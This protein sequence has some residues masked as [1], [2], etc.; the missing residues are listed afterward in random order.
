ML[1]DQY[2]SRM[3]AYRPV[4][5]D[6]WERVSRDDWE[7][8]TC[9]TFRAIYRGSLTRTWL[10]VIGAFILGLPILCL[11]L[12]S[13]QS[14]PPPLILGP[15]FAPWLTAL[16]LRGHLIEA[17]M[18]RRYL[19]KGWPTRKLGDLLPCNKDGNQ[20][21]RQEH[22]FCCTD[23][24]IGRPV[25][26]KANSGPGPRFSVFRRTTDPPG[27]HLPFSILPRR[28]DQL[29]SYGSVEDD[30]DAVPLSGILRATAGFPGI[31]PRLFQ[32]KRLRKVP[33]KQPTEDDPVERAELQ[34]GSAETSNIILPSQ[35]F[36]SDGGIWN[37]LATEPFEDQFM[38]DKRGPWDMLVSDA[39][40][41]PTRSCR[42][43]LSIPGLA[44]L[45]ALIREEIILA[46]NTVGPRLQMYMH[47]VFTELRQPAA[48]RFQIERMYPIVS[49]AETPEQLV[50]RFRK[51][52]EAPEEFKY[53]ESGLGIPERYHSVKSRLDNLNDPNTNDHATLAAFQRWSV[54]KP[55]RAVVDPVAQYSTTLAAVPIESAVA[56]V[57]RGYCNAALT[58]YLC[59][60][61]ETLGCPKGWLH[62]ELSYTEPGCSGP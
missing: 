8:A 43:M 20:Y 4:S 55:H 51:D 16:F 30:V 50:T 44:E 47:D 56:I 1:A 19:G 9:N 33:L 38:L 6:D 49:I 7:R 45:T 59:N 11:I 31:P 29:T 5:R 28:P 23:L 35:G 17:L 61:S 14:L 34:P 58:L 54:L 18:A 48:L 36:L 26:F 27:G 13:I 57:A 10:A 40:G 62:G 37:N 46:D 32:W 2:F 41:R 3:A 12:Y 53:K 52:F 21:F 22:V 39:S 25:H 60:L 42:L 15:I 24:L